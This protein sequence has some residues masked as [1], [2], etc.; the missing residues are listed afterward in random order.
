MLKMTYRSIRIDRMTLNF[1]SSFPCLPQCW[2]I[3]T[4]HHCYFMHYCGLNTKL[5]VCFVRILEIHLHFPCFVYFFQTESYYVV[6]AELK[7]MLFHYLSKIIKCDGQSQRVSNDSRLLAFITIHKKLMPIG[8]YNSIK[9]IK[10]RN[11]RSLV[12]L[13][14]FQWSYD[15]LVETLHQVVIC[16]SHLEGRA[17]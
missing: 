7:F 12:S 10:I 13:I 5:D 1:W 8:V 16:S 4:Y 11:C 14:R 3:D 2:I 15:V 17:F 6:N 9:T